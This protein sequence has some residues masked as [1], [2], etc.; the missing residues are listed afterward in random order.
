[1][2]SQR[3]IMYCRSDKCFTHISLRDGKEMMIC[4]SLS[5]V[6]EDLHPK[7]FL[8]IS[9]THL[10]NYFHISSIDKKGKS[11]T[12]TPNTTVPFTLTIKQLIGMLKKCDVKLHG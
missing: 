4:E 5:K 2:V 6:S 1:M 3:D 8:R 7:Y 11:I 9:R 12:L 10:V